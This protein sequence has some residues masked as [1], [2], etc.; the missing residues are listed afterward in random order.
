MKRIALGL[1]VAVLSVAGVAGAS[2]GIDAFVQN[3]TAGVDVNAEDTNVNCQVNTTTQAASCSSN[4]ADPDQVI[5]DVEQA[6]SDAQQAVSD[7]QTTVEGLIPPGPC[8]VAAD[9]ESGVNASCS[10][11]FPASPSETPEQNIPVD[12]LPSQELLPPTSTDPLTIPSLSID[13]PMVG[14]ITTPSVNVGSLSIPAINSPEVP[15]QTITVPSLP[16]PSLPETTCTI[17]GAVS[18]LG[19]DLNGGC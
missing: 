15:G 3:D 8:S 18:V 17:S 19:F 5:A 10:M 12:G 6:V 9:P 4:A 11:T 16:I 13:A 2:V 7:A 14:T 1:A